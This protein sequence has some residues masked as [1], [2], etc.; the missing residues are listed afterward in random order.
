MCRDVLRSVVKRFRGEVDENDAEGRARLAAAA[1]LV[2][3][4]G[5]HEGVEERERLAIAAAVRELFEL[6]ADV[7]EMLVAVAER[8]VDD[9]WH[10]WLFTE[11]IRGSFDLDARIALIDKLCEVAHANGVLQRFE[12]AFIERIAR[13]LEVPQ[14]HV[15]R[16]RRV[17]GA[18][19]V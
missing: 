16:C 8:R 14:E 19:A 13:E 9:V 2:E 18:E 7:A 4:A 3:C 12:D 5:V 6:D 15:E 17:A 11:A 10:D 1:L